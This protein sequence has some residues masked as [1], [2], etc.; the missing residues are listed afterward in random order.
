MTIV[1]NEYWKRKETERANRAQEALKHQELTEQARHNVAGERE[2]FRHNYAVEGET[3]RTNL[4]NE[5]IK[6]LEAN[7]KVLL[8]D[9]NIRLNDTRMAGANID[10]ARNQL[11]LNRDEEIYSDVNNELA[12]TLEPIRQGASIVGQVVGIVGSGINTV[13]SAQR[14]AMAGIEG[15]ANR[16]TK[17]TTGNGSSNKNV[18]TIGF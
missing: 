9:S 3:N 5:A 16:N 11:Q 13:G 4:A 15:S 18:R 1:Q 14:I 6:R 2:N 7:S 8:N 12:G 17:T 10:N